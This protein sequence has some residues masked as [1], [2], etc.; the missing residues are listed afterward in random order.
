MNT[1]LS[2]SLRNKQV[3]HCKY[4]ISLAVT[5]V[6]QIFKKSLP[7]IWHFYP[8]INVSELKDLEKF[9]LLN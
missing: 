9:T 1:M 3:P 4:I 8:K 7:Y 5:K 6:Q 2:S